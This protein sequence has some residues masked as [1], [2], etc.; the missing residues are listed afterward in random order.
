MR[1]SVIYQ[2]DPRQWDNHYDHMHEISEIISHVN[3]QHD[4]FT[5]DTAKYNIMEKKI[6]I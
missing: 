1:F 3:L 6:S 4:V 2:P 5:G